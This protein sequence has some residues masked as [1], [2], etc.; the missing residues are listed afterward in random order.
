MKELIWIKCPKSWFPNEAKFTTW[1][2]WELKKL[3]FWKKKWS[4]ASWDR[5][6]YDC[7]IATPT[8]DYYCE[9]KHLKKDADF[10]IEIFRPNQIKAMQDLTALN[11]QAIVCIYSMPQNQYKVISWKN[12]KKVLQIE[13]K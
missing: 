9:I 13:K 4:D 3:W 2:L 12:L 6:P 11:K 8:S 1:W 7:N 10:W 5:K